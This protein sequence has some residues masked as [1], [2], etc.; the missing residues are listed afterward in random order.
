ML[1][2]GGVPGSGRCSTASASVAHFGRTTGLSGAPP[3]DSRAAEP[4]IAARL[5]GVLRRQDGGDGMIRVEQL[6]REAVHV[7]ERHRLV[8]RRRVVRRVETLEHQGLRPVLRQAADAVVGEGKLGEFLAPRGFHELGRHAIA[9][10]LRDDLPHLLQRRSRVAALREPGRSERIAN[11]GL[12]LVVEFRHQGP[13]RRHQPI[14]RAALAGDDVRQDVGRREVAALQSRHRVG[15]NRQADREIGRQPQR[16]RLHPPDRD[17]FMRRQ[18]V[19]RDVAECILHQR[20]R[21]L[22]SDVA[23]DHQHRVVG[24]VPAVVEA[25]QQR[26]VRLVEGGAGAE[27]VV[28]VRRAREHDRL[29]FR[30]EIIEWAGQIAGDLLLDRPAFQRPVVLIEGQPAHP[31]R[32]DPERDTQVGGRHGVEILRH[33]LGGVGVERA[34]EQRADLAE[35]VAVETAAAAE[36]HM[37]QRVRGAREAGGGIVGA[38][39]VVD[40]RRDHRREPVRHDHHLQPVR[41]R[42]AQHRRVR[43]GHRRGGRRHLIRSGAAAGEAG[44]RRE[45]GGGPMKPERPS[46]CA[47]ACC[48]GVTPTSLVSTAATRAAVV[49]QA[50]SLTSSSKSRRQCAAGRDAD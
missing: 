43:G 30:K 20:Q 44:D 46:E 2:S 5:P 9:G 3:N 8:G 48:H 28:L 19:A 42:G 6:P 15:Q 10:E 7:G 14:Q 38:D 41:Q 17:R 31:S 13:P 32:L 22:R 11:I 29:Q 18:F 12:G 50:I 1:T 25:A 4:A 21:C 45:E 33:G 47:D 39:E 37:L 34:A 35:L 16:L 24:R 36:H 40:L 49:R 26:R 27:R 23:G